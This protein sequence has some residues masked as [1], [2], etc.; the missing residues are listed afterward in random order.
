MFKKVLELF[1]DLQK[2]DPALSRALQNIRAGKGTAQDAN[3]LARGMY[4]DI[5]VPKMG[6]KM[7]YND[8]LQRHADNGYHVHVDLND[9]GQINK[10]HGDMAGDEA[11]KQFGHIGSETS[12]MFG[13]KAHRFGGDEF[14]FWFHKPEQAHGFAREL[15]ARLEK[16]P[17]VRGTH[18]LAASIGIGY[19]PDHAEGAL[20]E[21]KKQLGATD[22]KTGKR[23]NT[24]EIGNAPTV[25]H[26][27]THEAPP[28][29]WKQA[30]GSP[31]TKQNLPN[32]S[33]SSGL[34]FHNPLDPSKGT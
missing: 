20:L 27:K 31:P 14:K 15:R 33:G 6:N 7:A 30:A 13:G 32:L 28:P 8:H 9:F 24:H 5:M 19:T 2:M 34:K 18:N 23:N 1:S 22:I 25:I 17:K 3:V 21:A 11:I 12:R 4:T 16:H 29:H 10:K 26:S